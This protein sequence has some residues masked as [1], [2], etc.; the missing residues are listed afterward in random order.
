MGNSKGKLSKEVEKKATNIFH[1][2]DKDHSG[3]IDQKETM[4]FW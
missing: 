2:I 4:A 3:S 1:L